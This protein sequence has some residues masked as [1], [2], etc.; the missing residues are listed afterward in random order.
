MNHLS[1][2]PD[3]FHLY[4]QSSRSLMLS[5]VRFSGNKNDLTNWLTWFFLI[6]VI[7]CVAVQMNYLNKALDS[8]NTGI[9]T[10]VYYVMFT[11]MVLIASAILFK[12]WRN[13]NAKVS[14]Y[15]RSREN[16]Q[17]WSCALR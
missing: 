2:L 1:D 11:T 6:M 4:P 10:P 16:D 14:E 9:V 15:D 5:N 8:F 17:V 7:V 13:L 12:E 3:V